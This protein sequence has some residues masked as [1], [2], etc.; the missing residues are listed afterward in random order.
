MK[1]IVPVAMMAVLGLATGLASA[2]TTTAAAAATAQPAKAESTMT[3]E[4]AKRHE[5][6]KTEAQAKKVAPGAHHEF[7][8]SC[9]AGTAAPAAAPASKY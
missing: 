9:M 8:K 5:A 1:I 7:M 3:A 4:L 6:C 2:A